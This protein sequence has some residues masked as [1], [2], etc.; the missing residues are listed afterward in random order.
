MR[1]MIEVKEFADGSAVIND[2]LSVNKNGD[3]TVGRN[4]EVEGALKFEVKSIFSDITF[5]TAQYQPLIQ[6]AFVIGDSVFVHISVKSKVAEPQAT[7]ATLPAA[8]KPIEDTILYGC[9]T[10]QDTATEALSYNQNVNIKARTN[11]IISN[12]G[13]TLIAGD[14]LEFSGVYK[15]NPSPVQT[16]STES[17]H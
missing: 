8:Y 14:V 7:V 6:T 11:G 12:Y 2:G 17:H 3:V 16:V 10:R 5:N 1:R 9:A 15:Y 13:S 4:L